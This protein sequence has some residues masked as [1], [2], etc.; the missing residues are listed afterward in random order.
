MRLVAGHR[1]NPTCV[2]V[3]ARV[4]VSS[5]L[6]LV[7]F[8]IVAV[9][10][11]TRVSRDEAYDYKCIMAS[12]RDAEYKYKVECADS[13]VA[14]NALKSEIR[15]LAS[16][17]KVALYDGY[18]DPMSA[19]SRLAAVLEGFLLRV[20]PPQARRL[21]E[22]KGV[23]DRSSLSIA[24]GC[25]YGAG[26]AGTKTLA[27]LSGMESPMGVPRKG[28]S[29]VA[30]DSDAAEAER[31]IKGQPSKDYQ[32]EYILTK[33]D[34][35]EF[36]RDNEDAQRLFSDIE[37]L[38]HRGRAD[39][40][41]NSNAM[42]K[43][44]NAK[45]DNAPAEEDGGELGESAKESNAAGSGG[46][47]DGGSNSSR[48][49]GSKSARR[50]NSHGS[51]SS[52]QASA[53]TFRGRIMASF[54]S[55]TSVR[56]R[57]VPAVPPRNAP[58][59]CSSSSVDEDIS[60]VRARIPRLSWVFG[61]AGVGKS[62]FLMNMV[63]RL[64]FGGLSARRTCEFVYF[65]HTK[66][67][68]FAEVRA[69]LVSMLSTRAHGKDAA[70]RRGPSCSST[71]S[72]ANGGEEG[73]G[74][75]TD[76]LE[77]ALRKWL[78]RHP[79]IDLIIIIDG[80]D[81]ITSKNVLRETW[82]LLDALLS[83]SESSDRVRILVSSR[84]PMTRE[85][86][87]ATERTRRAHLIFKSSA[88]LQLCVRYVHIRPISTPEKKAIIARKASRARKTMDESIEDM[89]CLSQATK[90]PRYL[91]ILM[92]ELLNF[93]SFDKLHAFAASLMR[94]RDATEILS[95]QMDRLEAGFN[96]FLGGIVQ[97][98]LLTLLEY[99][100]TNPLNLHELC[101][102]VADAFPE[103]PFHYIRY[104]TR[105]VLSSS[106]HILRKEAD[107]YFVSE[108]ARDLLVLYYVYDHIY[109]TTLM[110]FPQA[111][112]ESYVGA[113][114][115]VIAGLIRCCLHIV[116]VVLPWFGRRQQRQGR[117]SMV[118]KSNR[119]SRIAPIVSHRPSSMGMDT[120]VTRTFGSGVMD[121]R[122]SISRLS[123]TVDD[124]LMSTRDVD[125]KRSWF[126][127]SETWRSLADRTTWE[128]D[129]FDELNELGSSVDEELGRMNGGKSIAKTTGNVESGYSSGDGPVGAISS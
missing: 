60:V 4:C 103:P 55:P 67:A 44:S 24:H 93:G 107:V 28:G 121:N 123:Y 78:G 109:E 91:T 106:T 85:C 96:I 59:D 90:N 101:L 16:I 39:E 70:S 77:W 37:A 73:G 125:G 83:A 61:E 68:T 56:D 105:L 111:L 50:N 80:L 1:L 23:L 29:N 43:G 92:D 94:A 9:I 6:S 17:N 100:D 52:R 15:E 102:I 112:S 31:V 11:H 114:G 115:Y 42:S 82:I 79:G 84:R 86:M 13:E 71:A 14:L 48:R 57:G 72:A 46:N 76:D 7:V 95:F 12:N 104:I 58:G 51:H 119:F 35:Y 129:A 36:P 66:R 116:D 74:D 117:A 27:R 127:R 99:S 34:T 54:Y 118:M 49:S 87:S 32:S 122:G 124:Q 113:H 126:G 65:F 81:M 45:E 22:L 30:A 63:F 62:S 25:G 8:A 18:P 20:L 75:D 88:T 120:G 41:H 97:K 26:F 38:T 64:F 40:A 108:P 2:F 21:T 47:G 19:A 5:S 128:R 3:R 10:S 53:Q 98:I 89:L 33:A 110:E 69:Q